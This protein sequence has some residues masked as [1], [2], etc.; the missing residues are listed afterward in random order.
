MPDEGQL[1]KDREYKGNERKM[2]LIAREIVTYVTFLFLLMMV[3]YG[4]RT[5]NGFLM[6]ENIK[7]IFGDFE[8]VKS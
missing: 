3:C 1:K 8:E 5:E 7:N 6:T 2:L 4:N